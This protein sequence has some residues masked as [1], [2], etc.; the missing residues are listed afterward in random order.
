MDRLLCLGPLDNPSTICSEYINLWGLWVFNSCCQSG[1]DESSSYNGQ[2]SFFRKVHVIYIIYLLCDKYADQNGM[3]CR[4]ICNFIV[5]FFV[6][7]M[8]IKS[9]SFSQSLSYINLVQISMRM[10]MKFSIPLHKI[11]NLICNSL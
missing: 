2:H 1:I 10:I 4:P 3:T 5:I 8:T 9:I 11:C 6:S 7:K